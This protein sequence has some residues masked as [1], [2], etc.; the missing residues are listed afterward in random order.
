MNS[1]LVIC[2]LIVAASAAPSK[3]IIVEYLSGGE[4]V[5]RENCRRA[6]CPPINCPPIDRPPLNPNCGNVDCSVRNNQ[7]F[8]WPSVDATMYYQCVPTNAIGGW[9]AMPRNCACGSVFDFEKQRCVLPHEFRRVCNG[10]S[11][12]PVL[13]PCPTWCP[14]CDD[15]IT[16]PAP[17]TTT[18]TTLAPTTTTTT[19]APTTTTTTLAP[20]TTTT[21]LAPTTTTT[22]LAPT[23][24]T[25]RVIVTQTQEVATTPGQNNCQCPCMPCI[26]WPCFIVFVTLLAY[27]AA[28]SQLYDDIIIVLSKNG[29]MQ[30]FIRCDAPIQSCPRVQCPDSRQPIPSIPEVPDQ[31]IPDA[32]IQTNPQQPNNNCTPCGPCSLAVH[33]LPIVRAMDNLNE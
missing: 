18:T 7:P 1:F 30:C 27:A 21:T 32:P 13:R 3:D 15:P 10:A 5:C 33:V 12:I 19:L 16:T 31:R 11:D 23:T 29:D 25:T 2:C 9:G 17:I 6:V 8:L 20:T 24:T 14:T 4:R 26:W 28:A 22:T